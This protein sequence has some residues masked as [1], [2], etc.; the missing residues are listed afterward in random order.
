M[1]AA[2]CIPPAANKDLP[3]SMMRLLIL[4]DLHRN[5]WR[6]HAVSIDTGASRPDLVILAGDI[7]SGARGVD[8]A[9]ESFPGLPVLYVYGN[10][11]AYGSSV[12]ALQG[13]LAAA[14]ARWPNVHLL[15]CGEF[16]LPGV[17]FLGAPLW[18]DFRLFG[19]VQRLSAMRASERFLNDYTSISVPEQPPRR[20]RA[21]DT[22]QWH[23]AQ[24]AWLQAR[25]DEPFDG[26]TV[27]ITHMAPS[28]ASVAQRYATDPVSAAYASNLEE[29]VRKADLW[30]HGHTHDSFDYRI[31]ECR[32]LCNPDGY[33]LSGGRRENADFD[34]ELVI[35]V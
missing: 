17:R 13:E 8:W 22:A 7:D 20:L 30:V 5:Q 27:V 12:P 14:C 34:P 23:A 16:R 18:T 6:E 19:D 10:H 21:E 31:G 33:R 3:G 9:G 4:S 15:D 24:R 29:L 25:L 28:L 35:E 11:E 26:K 1:A 2:V 32:V